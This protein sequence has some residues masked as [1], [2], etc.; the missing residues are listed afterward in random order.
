MTEDRKATGPLIFLI[1]GEPSGDQLGARLMAALQEQSAEEIRFMGI[2]GPLMAEQGLKSL[3]PIED[4]AVMGIFEV[5][6]HIAKI[7]RRV[8]ATIEAVQMARPAVL[9]TIDSPSF[10][11]QVSKRLQGEGIPL[12]HYVAPSVWAW[13]AWRAKKI[14]DYLDCLLTL[15][16]F[17]PPYFEAHGLRAVFVGHPVV[18]LE[19][20]IREKQ[21]RP[22]GACREE[23]GLPGCDPL[24]CLLPGSRRGE[25]TRLLPIFKEV[26]ERLQVN[27]PGL[28]V[29]LP[30]VSTVA[31]V[32]KNAVQEWRVPVKVLL[33]QEA[34]MTAYASS[35]L[36]IAASGTVAVE[37]A[38]AGLP[39]V[40]AYRVNPI[41]AHLAKRI[42]KIRHVSLPNI[43]LDREVQPELLQWDCTSKNI[44]AQ[45]LS[46]LNEKP[47]RDAQ[48]KAYEEVRGILRPGNISPS[49]AAA[50]EILALI[51]RN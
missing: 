7:Y 6:P 31:E 30:T 43:L 35:D 12:V 42:L 17:E 27:F 19:E 34:K 5:V 39:A 8:M 9:V 37:L 10:S 40:I 44:A 23:L 45:S 50:R 11:L 28:G 32:L 25:V 1:A 46:L 29:V 15:L 13:K 36:A 49:H 26:V 14:S 47:S 16:P 22:R 48:I 20:A 38:V 21:A 33:G 4:F 2:G 51:P 24:L 3:F 18:E 41:T